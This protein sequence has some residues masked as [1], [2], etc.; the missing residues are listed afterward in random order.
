MRATLCQTQEEF[1][2]AGHGAIFLYQYF[3]RS[4]NGGKSGRAML[5]CPGCGRESGMHLRSVGIPH[6]AE[7]SSWEVSGL[8]DNITLTPS[9]NCTGCCQWHGWLIDGE[10][11]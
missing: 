1:D 7:S 2:A 8:P 11:K 9:V 5:K 10:W 4:N 3:Q 6:P